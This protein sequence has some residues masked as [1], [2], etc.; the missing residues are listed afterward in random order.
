MNQQILFV[1]QAH[2]KDFVFVIDF[3]HV[4]LYFTIIRSI[5]RGTEVRIS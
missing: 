5:R 2:E 1:P 3:F 4:V